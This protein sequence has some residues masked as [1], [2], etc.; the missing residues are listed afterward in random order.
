MSV[1][2]LYQNLTFWLI[3]L[4]FR[5]I[6]L[7][8]SRKALYTIH[9]LPVLPSSLHRLNYSSEFCVYSSQQAWLLR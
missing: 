8:Y 9:H 1:N 2:Q 7:Y 5:A 3:C 4:I 6:I